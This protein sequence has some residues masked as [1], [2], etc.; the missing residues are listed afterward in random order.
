MNRHRRLAVQFLLLTIVFWSTAPSP[1]RA[2]EGMWLFNNPP[3]ELLKTKYHFDV[4]DAWLDHLMH[5]AVRFNSGGSGS[6]VSADGLVMTNHHVA[7]DA[8]QKLSTSD[9]DL[10]ATGFYAKTRDAEIKCLDL[11]LNVLQGIEDVTARVNGAVKTDMSP[12]DA[13]KARRA[14]M[15]TIEQEA[16]EKTGLRCDVVTLYQGGRYHL[17]RYKKYTDVR[18]VF[19]PEKD[20]AFFGG[21]PDNFEYPRYNLDC[22]FFRAYEDG[23]PAHVQHFFKW[24]AGGPADGELVFVVGHP[25]R[26]KRSLTVADIE[27]SRDVHVTRALDRMRRREV[28]LRTYAERSAENARRAQDEL[29]GVQ[30][31]RKRLIGILAGLQDPSLLA[32]VRESEKKLRS[33]AGKLDPDP[34]VQVKEVIAASDRIY[35]DLGLFEYG[36]GFDCDLF[37]IARSIVRLVDETPKPNAQRLRDYRES[38]LES[39]K[40]WLFSEAPIYT[41]LE[42]IKLADALSYLIEKKGVNDPLVAQVL[43]GH[44]P[45]DRAAELIAK[46]RVADVAVRKQLATLSSAELAKS[47]DPMIQLARLVDPKARELREIDEQQDEVQR[48]AYAKIAAVRFGIDGDRTYPDATFTL[49]LAFGI[50]RGYDLPGAGVHIP[51]WTTLA[52]VFERSAQH[53][54]APPFDLPQ[55][56]AASKSKLDGSV[57]FNFITTA[58]VVGGNSGSPCVNRKGEVVGLI[59][60]GNLD[61]LVLDFAYTEQTARSLAVHTGAMLEALRKV[62]DAS[63]L[64]DEITGVA[65]R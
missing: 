41:D 30:N 64:A 27:F 52:G 34:W 13:E 43:A 58:D 9:R 61:S 10:V 60:D 33:A 40:Q 26:T 51:A 14:V 47:D 16:S 19:A 55:S 45:R 15:N 65:R 46:T 17:Y 53:G 49:R 42:T 59:F 56:W 48:Q 1:V 7:T 3:R 31:E 62:Y 63:D 12:A 36:G 4:D 28:L 44:S 6:F 29:F 8:L 2:D 25:G 38:N 57:P 39:L 50:V 20:I 22:A 11:E 24:N 5:S 35:I 18:L 32:N 21:D 37:D 54:N 23:K